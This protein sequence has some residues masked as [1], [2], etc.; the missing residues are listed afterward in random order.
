[1]LLWGKMSNQ[2]CIWNGS[3][4]KGPRHGLITANRQTLVESMI[5]WWHQTQSSVAYTQEIIL[6]DFGNA[7]AYLEVDCSSLSLS[8]FPCCVTLPRVD[9]A[10]TV[11]FTSLLWFVVVISDIQCILVMTVKLLNQTPLNPPSIIIDRHV[12]HYFHHLPEV[13]ELCHRHLLHCVGSLG[14]PGTSDSRIPLFGCANF[15]S[16]RHTLH[17]MVFGL[18]VTF[19]NQSNSRFV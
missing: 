16:S 8:W 4:L 7:S 19:L 17:W 9:S 11:Q 12:Y 18:C 6:F 14:F 3:W 2:Q 15:C 1:M 13:N 10:P 5:G